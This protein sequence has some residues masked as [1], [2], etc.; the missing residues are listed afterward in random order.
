MV[1]LLIGAFIII[2]I[3]DYNMILKQERKKTFII[4]FSLLILGFVLNLLLLLNKAPLSPVI[5]IEKIVNF[6]V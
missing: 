6:F 1:V 4:Y 3:F 5:I 2:G